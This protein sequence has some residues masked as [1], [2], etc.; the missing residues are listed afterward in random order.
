MATPEFLIIASH[1][2]F[3]T[4]DIPL[5]LLQFASHIGSCLTDPT[6]NF[7]FGLKVVFSD[8]FGEYLHASTELLSYFRISLKA[9]RMKNRTCWI[10]F[11]KW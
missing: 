2:A 8:L 1:F 11:V 3:C 9:I 6:A 7:F 5:E 4:T 10:I